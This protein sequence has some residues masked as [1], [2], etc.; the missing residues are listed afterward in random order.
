MWFK[1]RQVQGIKDITGRTGNKTTWYNTI[2]VD[3][4][5]LRDWNHKLST[6]VN[7]DVPKRTVNV[8]V[9]SVSCRKCCTAE[10]AA[11]AEAEEPTNGIDHDQS[12][13]GEQVW[14]WV[15]VARRNTAHLITP[16]GII[17][18]EDPH[19]THNDPDE[20]ENRNQSLEATK[21]IAT[22]ALV[23][24]LITTVFLAEQTPPNNV[25]DRLEETERAEHNQPGIEVAYPRTVIEINS[26]YNARGRIGVIHS[27]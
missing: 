13:E 17:V 21:A 2:I 8:W 24:V 3:I 19:T 7:N 6:F 20:Q 4:K 27:Y 15:T 11:A 23:A 9:V 25:H 26:T 1:F 5:F 16:P 10:E 12:D 18:P 22:I 14:D